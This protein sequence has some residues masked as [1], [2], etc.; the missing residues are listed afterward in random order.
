MPTPTY[1]VPTRCWCTTMEQ[2][3]QQQPMK[4]GAP[5]PAADWMGS[6][7]DAMKSRRQNPR[8][9]PPKKAAHLSDWV[10]GCGV[11]LMGPLIDRMQGLW[12]MHSQWDGKDPRRQTHTH[13]LNT[14]ALLRPSHR[15]L[16]GLVAFAPSSGSAPPPIRLAVKS[17]E[18]SQN[19]IRA[20]AALD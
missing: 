8:M 20:N 12:S 4:Q 11:S 3:Q 17:I 10:D 1:H 6:D 5:L 15:S 13:A 2:Q 19:Q 9:R 7:D 18:T 16:V 14:H